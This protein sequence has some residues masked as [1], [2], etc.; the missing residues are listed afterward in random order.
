MQ[1]T[2]FV[3]RQIRRGTVF[4]AAHP[5]RFTDHDR[6]YELV[7]TNGSD[8][9]SM[10]LELIAVREQQTVAKIGYSGAGRDF[11]ISLFEQDLPLEVVEQL[12]S[13][14]RVA[15]LPATRVHGLW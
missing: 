11:T 10:T 7:R 3:A 5:M 8:D 4:M 13:A 6:D 2:G 12:I 15:L 1:T 14:A 9:G